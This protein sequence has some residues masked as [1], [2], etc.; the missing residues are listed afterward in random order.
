M[1]WETNPGLGFSQL[2]VSAPNYFDWVEQ[3][4]VFEDL[5]AV[6]AIPD[7]GFNFVVKG[8]PER[9]QAGMASASLFSLLGIQAIQGRTFLPAEDRPGGAPVVLISQGLWQ[10]KFGADPDI[11]GRPA[12]VDGLSRTIIGVLPQELSSLAKVDAWVPLGLAPG[13]GE[14]YAHNFGVVARM[15]P[16]VSLQQAQTDVE[17]IASRLATEYPDTNTGFGARVTPL[18]AALSGGIGTALWILLGAVGIL[19][20]I[21]C[22]NVANLLLARATTRGKEIAVRTALGATRARVL[23]QLLT[24]SVLLAVVGGGLGLGL[25]A[26]SIVMLR[27]FLPDIIPRLKEMNMDLRVLVVTFTVSLVTGVVFGLAPA[28]KMSGLKPNEELKAVGRGSLGTSTHRAQSLLLSAETALALVLAIGAALLMKSF[29]HL[30]AVDPGLHTANILTMQLNLPTAKYREGFQRTAFFDEMM[31]RV[32]ALPGVESAGAVTLPPLWGTWTGGRMFVQPFQI[33]GR[34]EAKPGSEPTADFRVVSPGYFSTVGIPL[35]KGRYFN[36]RDTGDAAPVLV[37]NETL[38]RRYFPNEDPLGNRLRVGLE[39]TYR[40]IVGVV[41]DAKLYGLDAPIE[42]AY[43]KPYA[44]DPIELM[45][46]MVRGSRDPT[47]L[48][49]AIRNEV[50]AIDEQQPVA[51]VRTMDEVLLQS[52]MPRLFSVWLFGIFAGLALLLASVGIYGLTSYS[53][54]RRTREFG[55][56]MALGAGR[57]DVLRTVIKNGLL[58]ALVGVAIGLGGAFVLS[59]VM[60]SLLFGITA[61]DPIVFAV[62]PLI[63]V[64]VA[65]FAAYVPARKATKVDPIVALRYE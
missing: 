7:F 41:G 47:G 19:L 30:M 27:D 34:P 46:L 9:V 4:A 37:I 23:Q 31:R 50:R 53:V 35:R 26:L 56:R 42:P 51:N 14:R 60:S 49:S 32:E 59:R 25:A 16:G 1:V 17:T 24:E 33:A 29:A 18:A 8:E 44:Q 54:S 64:A 45:T 6:V 65:G 63:L 15:K 5:A 52:L 40:E 11:V 13:V 3:N 21:A 61:T 57:W 10:A 22:V 48:T 28:V 55:L 38:A 12:V 36:A 62:V 58:A 39:S 20:L 43:Y 2:P